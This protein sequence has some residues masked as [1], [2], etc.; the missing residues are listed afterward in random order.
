MTINEAIELLAQVTGSINGTRAQHE[1]I[2]LALNTIGNAI[3]RLE[4]LDKPVAKEEV[5]TV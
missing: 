4:G 3:R 2:V 1:K 5:V